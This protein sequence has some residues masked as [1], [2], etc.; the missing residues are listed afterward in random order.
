[1]REGM[2]DRFETEGEIA[3][4]ETLAKDVIVQHKE[5]FSDSDVHAKDYVYETPNVLWAV[6]KNKTQ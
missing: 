2:V 4:V 5:M 6:D 1:M 3:V